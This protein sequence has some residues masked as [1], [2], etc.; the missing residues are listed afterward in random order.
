MYSLSN[1]NPKQDLVLTMKPGQIFLS[2]FRKDVAQANSLYKNLRRFGFCLWQDHKDLT[3]ESPWIEEIGNALDNS[4]FFM[5]CISRRSTVPHSGKLVAEMNE[6]LQLVKTRKTKNLFIVP[7]R[8]ED[9]PLPLEYEKY[10]GIDLFK[11]DGLE[12]LVKSLRYVLKQIGIKAPLLLRAQPVN[13]LTPEAAARMIRSRDFFDSLY[14]PGTGI[15]HTY[16]KKKVEGD[17]IIKDLTTGL[18]WQQSGSGEAMPHD[19]SANY[20]SYMNEISFAGYNDWR[21]PTL[22]EGMSLIEKKENNHGL[23]ISEVFDQFQQWVWTSD[24]KNPAAAWYIGFDDGYC[25]TD[26]IETDACVRAVR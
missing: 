4:S 13:D 8:L 24:K 25:D 12:E 3:G 7:V 2:Y 19:A 14:W 1:E 6:A 17:L 9:V 22:E 15:R 5:A 18:M 10:K 21:L 23:H 26:P 20:I 11:D 16:V